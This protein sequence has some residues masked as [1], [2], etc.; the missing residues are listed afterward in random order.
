MAL[1]KIKKEPNCNNV[2]VEHLLFE[3]YFSSQGV[4]EPWMFTFGQPRRTVCISTIFL[5]KY[6]EKNS[7]VFL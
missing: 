7:P 1:Y 5:G 6:P 4:V 2:S 3:E